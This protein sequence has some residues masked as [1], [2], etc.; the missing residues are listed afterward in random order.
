VIRTGALIAPDAR[1]PELR[2][3]RGDKLMPTDRDLHI[4]MMTRRYGIS[5]DSQHP[6]R[7]R[8]SLPIGEESR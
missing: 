7:P 3:R 8:S 4:G 6:T 2:V 1:T 5:L